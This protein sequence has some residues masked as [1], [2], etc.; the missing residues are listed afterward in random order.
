MEVMLQFGLFRYSGDYSIF[1]RVS[2][3]SLIFLVIYVDDIVITGDDS[4]WID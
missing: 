3:A 2:R 4:T 1:Y